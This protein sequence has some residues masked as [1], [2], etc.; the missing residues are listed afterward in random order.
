M[1]VFWQSETTRLIVNFTKLKR[2]YI[3]P[4][5]VVKGQEEDGLQK[6]EQVKYEYDK[7]HLKSKDL[8]RTFRHFGVILQNN[9]KKK[10]K[11]L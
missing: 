9:K 4:Q 8:L 10:F 5:L 7:P 1:F 3:L 11:Q 2:E 6:L